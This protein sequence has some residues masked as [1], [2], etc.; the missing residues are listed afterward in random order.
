MRL[1]IA[2]SSALILALAAACAD[3]SAEQETVQ[4]TL[5]DTTSLLVDIDAVVSFDSVTPVAQV[6]V[7]GQPSEQALQVFSDSG[8]VAV[9][10]LRG[11]EEK[12]RFDEK[13]AVEALGMDYVWLPIDDEDDVSFDNAA[14]LNEL[15]ASYDAPVLVHCKSGNRV[16]ALLAL[17]TGREGVDVETAIAYGKEGGLTRLEEHVR[18][19]L[20]SQE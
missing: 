9:I 2:L 8:Y 11:A 14:K 3:E 5:Q 1:A 19:Q 13:T 10:D 12:R 18:E 15:I 7:A 6:S 4:V 20:Q 17:Q 16:G